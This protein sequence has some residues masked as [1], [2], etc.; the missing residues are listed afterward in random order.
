VKPF[1][2][3]WSTLECTGLAIVFF[4]LWLLMAYPLFRAIRANDYQNGKPK[5]NK[6]A[7]ETDA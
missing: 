5:G 3:D 7:P 4:A 1:Y 2:A 6:P